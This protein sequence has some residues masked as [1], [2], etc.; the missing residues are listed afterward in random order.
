MRS[1]TV[2]GNHA[3]QLEVEQPLVP[4]EAAVLG[5]LD[6]LLDGATCP[7]DSTLQ[8][9]GATLEQVVLGSGERQYQRK[10]LHLLQPPTGELAEF[11]RP[12]GGGVRL[13]LPQLQECVHEPCEP[14]EIDED[15]RAV[16]GFQCLLGT[17]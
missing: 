6:A 7:G 3:G 17:G 13:R 4:S 9:F 11:A 5:Q 15:R 12:C 10:S 16:D 14:G 2:G 1:A 8:K